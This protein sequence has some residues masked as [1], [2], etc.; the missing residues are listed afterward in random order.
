MAKFQYSMV[1]GK[2]VISSGSLM[3][4]NRETA[5]RDLMRGGRK[6]I[7][8]DEVSNE[9]KW[10]EISLN[11]GLSQKE[12]ILITKRIANMTEHGFSVMDSLRSIELQ[13]QTPAL[14]DVIEHVRGRVELGNSLADALKQ[15][16]KYFSSVYVSIVRV[17]E[18]S[19]NLA[20]VLKY[21][22][23]QQTQSYELRRKAIGAMIY[24]AIIVS[25]MLIIAVGMI[26]FLIPFLKN[27]FSSFST[28]LPLAT[29][30][31]MNSE[32]FLKS[33]WWAITGGALVLYGIMRVLFSNPGFRIFWDRTLLRLPLLG[34]ILQSY[35]VAQIVRTFA[36]LNQSGVPMTESLNIMT[37]VPNN[38]CYKKAMESI[39][40]DVDHGAIFS[41]SMGKH[42]DI[43]PPLVIESIKLGERTGN[44]TDSS[45][46]LAELY[47]DEVKE[48]L[49]ILTTLIQ[50]LLL[51]I[52]GVMVGT[53]AIAIIMP[54]QRLPQL[55]Q[56]RQ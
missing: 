41:V 29:R 19:G 31:L 13:A 44:L 23:K 7:S 56:H 34:G 51:V 21:L 8:F 14:K 40:H 54:L 48:T 47:E 25:L 37:S 22:E 15:Y 20:K 46:Y 12:I 5:L 45:T 38:T 35:N 24:P 1:D 55:I 11:T 4:F 36:T 16:P 27:I 50:P 32:P 18:E 28:E 52:V 53:F 10:W 42:V 33:Y 43:F 39:K 30:I 2:G 17:G 9:K 6:V 3:S 49:E 26:I